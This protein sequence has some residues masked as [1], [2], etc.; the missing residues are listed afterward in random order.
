[1]HLRSASAW[2]IATCYELGFGTS[3]PPI[4]AI[5]F[6][7]ARDLNHP[8]AKILFSILHGK[9]CLDKPAEKYRTVVTKAFNSS[10]SSRESQCISLKQLKGA[11]EI[12]KLNLSL[13]RDHAVSRLATH[14]PSHFIIYFESCSVREHRFDSWMDLRSAFGLSGT[15]KL[16]EDLQ[17][18]MGND[19]FLHGDSFIIELPDSGNQL[20]T[21]LE[22][23]VSHGDCEI[24]DILCKSGAGVDRTTLAQDPVLVQA[25]QSGLAKTVFHLLQ[26]GADPNSQG[27]DGSSMFHWLF[28]LD[29]AGIACIEQ[30]L[31]DRHFE[32][33]TI[34]TPSTEPR[35]LHRQWPLE[36][37]GTSLA[38]AISTAN[39]EAVQSL[40]RLGADPLAPVYE[41]SQILQATLGRRGQPPILLRNII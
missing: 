28:A 33:L 27:L 10:K 8:V 36:F 2:Q 6:A 21:L 7:E 12:G 1:M 40:L 39:M 30:W 18:S 25:C 13:S 26:Q 20:F 35:Y 34:N 3:S 22:A 4:S 9:D 23:A 19:V 14:T 5:E 29:S 15:S 16:N 24:I 37:L 11:L 31:K 32:C 41:P 17:L 38:F